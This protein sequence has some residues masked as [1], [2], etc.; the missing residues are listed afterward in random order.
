M[1]YA[2]V[3]GWQIAVEPAVLGADMLR[4]VADRLPTRLLKVASAGIGLAADAARI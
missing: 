3:E 1:H 4:S 2:F